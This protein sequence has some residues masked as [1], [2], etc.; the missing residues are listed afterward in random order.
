MDKSARKSQNII[1]L[2][3]GIAGALFLHI[4][5]FTV[6]GLSN[7]RAIIPADTFSAPTIISMNLKN[8]ANIE[9]KV[10]QAIEPMTERAKKIPENFKPVVQKPAI[11]KPA[12]IKPVKE[13]PKK[14]AK[15][16]S[17]E[18]LNNIEPAATLVQKPQPL[19]IAPEKSSSTV[20]VT[21]EAVSV[22]RDIKTK[23]RR[24]QPEYPKSALR[25]RQEG[26]VLLRVL[27]SD[28]G[29][30][31]EIKIHQPSPYA[32]LNHAAI[33]AVKRW[34]FKPNIVNGRAVRSWVEIPIEFK[35]Q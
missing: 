2:S 31:E 26:I 32:A 4:L 14:T 22:T 33:K 15:K 29:R 35:I 3:L 17:P 10:E 21:Q 16:P 23:G 6:L 18:K 20:A 9:K 11:K 28:D 1:G 13:R 19:E 34:K 27:I 8:P 7:A 5:I 24:V 25:Q 30:R 12:K